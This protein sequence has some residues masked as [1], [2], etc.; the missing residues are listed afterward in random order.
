MVDPA[1]LEKVV[2]LSPEDRRDLFE[3]VQESI[4]P[5]LVALIDERE[6]QALAGSSDTR[7]WVA[8]RADLRE[9]YGR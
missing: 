7:P 5:E 2:S 4:D 1:L 9:Q 6:A 3:A 8:F